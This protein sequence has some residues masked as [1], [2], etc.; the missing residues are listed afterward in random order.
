M[1]NISVHPSLLAGLVLTSLGAAVRPLA[2]E[3]ATPVAPA[4]VG[5]PGMAYSLASLE[6]RHGFRYEGTSEVFGPVASTGRIDFDGLGGLRAEYT[7]SLGS[8]AF[9]G[10][11]IG[12]YTVDA[13]GTGSV[14]LLLPEL[15]AVAHGNFV[16]VDGGQGAYFTSTDLGY[17]ITGS[18][19]R[20]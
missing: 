8:Q 3:L 19:R 6:G 7:T 10:S 15:N 5:G 14:T 18:T 17:S 20:M 11:F 12:T 1:R 16:I 13:N 4:Q 2:G 9:T